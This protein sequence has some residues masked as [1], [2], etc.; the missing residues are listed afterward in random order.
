ME[1]MTR[2]EFDANAARNDCEHWSSAS[3]R[4]GYHHR[5]LE[6]I[7]SMELSHPSKVLEMGTM[8]AQLVHGSHTLDY[9]WDFVG[10]QTTHYHDARIVPWP[11]SDKQYDL[12]VALR[13]FHHLRPSVEQCFR[14][15]LR[16]A[17]R[18]LIGADAGTLDCDVSSA[19]K[20]AERFADWGLPAPSAIELNHSMNTHI[21]FWG[22]T[23]AVPV[24][25]TRMGN[26]AFFFPLGVEPS[27]NEFAVKGYRGPLEAIEA[28]AL[29]RRGFAA[30][31]AP[32]AGEI[33]RL[34]LDINGLPHPWCP[35]GYETGVCSDSGLSVELPVEK[36]FAKIAKEHF[37]L[38]TRLREV[39]QASLSPC[40]PVLYIDG[41]KY[42][43]SRAN[44]MHPDNFGIYKG[45]LVRLDWF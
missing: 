31:V 33:V 8:G 22:K 45:Q 1:Y 44:D 37:D 36:G 27:S 18:V 13:V 19:Q 34:I 28:W 26:S 39:F 11:I 43:R 20:V 41:V 24:R 3:L 7:K 38:Y 42:D 14:E 17:D 10:K 21:Y 2:E 15:A 25:P 40:H 4:W 5:A 35:F 16:V 12:F 23:V 6:I 29:Q 30:G 32:P 9:D